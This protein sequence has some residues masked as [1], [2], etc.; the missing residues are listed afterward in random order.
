MVSL[1]ARDPAEGI[2]QRHEN[3]QNRNQP[4]H[5]P[6]VFHAGAETRPRRGDQHDG[7]RELERGI[8]RKPRRQM[9]SKKFETEER[10]QQAQDPGDRPQPEVNHARLPVQEQKHQRKQQR[11]DFL[12][13]KGRDIHNRAGG[14]HRFSLR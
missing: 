4:Q 13:I 14:V 8:R 12:D 6:P 1:Q 11:A 9:G 2:H 3:R 10:G 5:R 7:E